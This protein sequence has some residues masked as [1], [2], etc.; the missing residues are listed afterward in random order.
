MPETQ[1]KWRFTLAAGIFSF[2]GPA[3]TVFIQT[4]QTD[5]FPTSPIY[6]AAIGVGIGAL[7][8]WRGSKA[9]GIVCLLANGA[10]LA[11]YGFLEAVGGIC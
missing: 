9:A 5:L 4:G 6:I 2:L 7:S 8:I 10:V 1:A 3:S 11:L